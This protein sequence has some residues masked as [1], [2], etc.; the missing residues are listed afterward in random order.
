[1]KYIGIINERLKEQG[2]SGELCLF[3][4]AVMCLVF[5]SRSVTKDVDA[6][7]APTAAFYRIIKNIADEYELPDDW[8]NP[9][10]KGFVSANHDVQLFEKLSHLTIYAASAPYMLAMKCLAARGDTCD[11]ED[12]RFLL[13]YL[14]IQSVDQAV[15]LLAQYY[16]QSRVLPRTQYF[17]QELLES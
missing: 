16:P 11:T 10:V 2:L 1:M 17:L 14:N 9:S 12:I 5:D 7:F 6:I 13:Q 15:Q 3:G 8:L 4:G